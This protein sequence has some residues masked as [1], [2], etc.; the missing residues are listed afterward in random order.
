MRMAGVSRGRFGGREREEVIGFIG[1]ILPGSVRQ[2][3]GEK[4]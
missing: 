3:K 1:T 2:E 4:G